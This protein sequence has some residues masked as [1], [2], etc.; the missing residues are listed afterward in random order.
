MRQA[1]PA[2]IGGRRLT[3]LCLSVAAVS[4]HAIVLWQG[5][6]A[7]PEFALSIAET[8]SLVGFGIALIA[9]LA[10][11]RQARFAGASAILLAIAGL[12]AVTTNEGSR[13]FAVTQQ[14]WELN[15][16]IALSVLAYSLITVGTGLAIALTF[17]DRRLRHRQ[18]LGWFSI[19]PSVATLESGMFNALGGGFA[20]LSLA[21]FSGFFFIDD[22]F[23]Q[24]LSRKVI[25]SCAAWITLGALLFG[26]W[27]FGWRGRMA[28]NWT[29]GGYFLLVLAYFGSKLVL[30]NVLGRHW[31]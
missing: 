23:A 18:P 31:G 10:C 25:L 8:A 4:V 30:E 26:R 1:A 5:V 12:V 13:E 6:S 24:S 3:G 27:R 16:H 2:T 20:A 15:I 22:I 29:L 28:R 9:V 7:K 21:L 14:G 17:L 19:L 11:V